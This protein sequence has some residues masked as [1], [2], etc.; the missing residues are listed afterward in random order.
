MN[1]VDQISGKSAHDEIKDLYDHTGKLL[2][3]AE[4]G[5]RHK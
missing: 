2:L 3:F 5:V 4:S 1:E